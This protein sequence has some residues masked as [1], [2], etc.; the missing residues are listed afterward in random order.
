MRFIISGLSFGK[1]PSSMS[2][3]LIPICSKKLGLNTSGENYRT[4]ARLKI[5]MPRSFTCKSRSDTIQLV[6][7]ASRPTPIFPGWLS[8][9][10]I[11]WS[12]T[13][14]TWTGKTT[15]SQSRCKTWRFWSWKWPNTTT[16][17]CTCARQKKC[18]GKWLPM[19]VSPKSCAKQLTGEMMIW[20]REP[21]SP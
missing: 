7:S 16:V 1:K 8:C 17:C 21:S 2:C 6:M 12:R 5:L 13:R 19:L 10:K 4:R 9:S 15:A 14:Q 3:Q 11:G 20:L 18:S